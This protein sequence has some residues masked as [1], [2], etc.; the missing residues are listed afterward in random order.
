MVILMLGAQM[1]MSDQLCKRVALQKGIGLIPAK[2]YSNFLSC[3]Q[4][5]V[6][7]SENQI[8]FLFLLIWQ[9]RRNFMCFGSQKKLVAEGSIENPCFLCKKGHQTLKIVIG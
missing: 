9:G 6:K 4:C 5:E 1:K 2:G 3:K 7:K 8:V